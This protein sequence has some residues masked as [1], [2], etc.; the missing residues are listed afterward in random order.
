MIWAILEC[1]FQICIPRHFRLVC[2][3]SST[4]LGCREGVS[5]VMVTLLLTFC[6]C[7]IPGWRRGERSDGGEKGRGRKEGEREGKEERGVR[8]GERERGRERRRAE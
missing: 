8:E 6:G 5:G 1:V 3:N 4:S 2:S 7:H